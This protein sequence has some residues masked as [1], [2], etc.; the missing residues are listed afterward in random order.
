[1]GALRGHQRPPLGEVTLAL[2]PALVAHPPFFR[3]EVSLNSSLK[4]RTSWDDSSGTVARGKTGRKEPPSCFAC[5]P[6]RFAV[7]CPVLQ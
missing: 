2:A 1:M 5:R 6:L 3:G 7:L 4:H